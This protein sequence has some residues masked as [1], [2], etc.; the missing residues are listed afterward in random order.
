MKY[1]NHG[2]YY[3]LDHQLTSDARQHLIMTLTRVIMEEAVAVAAVALVVA[4][5][6]LAVAVAVVA[7]C[8]NETL[9]K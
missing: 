8:M 1:C 3:Y 2:A 6:A 5:V 9:Q 7:F 4:A